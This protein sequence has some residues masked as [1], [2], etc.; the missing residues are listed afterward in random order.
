MAGQGGSYR[1]N[2]RLSTGGVTTNIHLAFEGQN[3]TVEIPERLNHPNNLRHHQ[4]ARP[5]RAEVEPGDPRAF[6]IQVRAK[7]KWRHAGI[8]DLKSAYIAA[9]AMF[10]YRYAFDPSLDLVREQIRNPDAELIRP[11]CWYQP[12]QPPRGPVILGLQGP[13]RGLLIPLG[14]AMVGL[15]WGGDATEF[16]GGLA[17]L[18]S[19]GK[20]DLS[21]TEL[22]WPSGPEMRLDFHDP[23]A[24]T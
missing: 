12:S 2:A 5:P 11:A 19:G 9:F 24:L 4:G 15:P 22:G 8:G 3:L 10:G 23:V 18:L 6:Q 13:F 14:R 20:V 1:G 17:E 16:Y 21:V 7:F